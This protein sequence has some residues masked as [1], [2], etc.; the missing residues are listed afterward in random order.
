M[1]RGTS[2]N[3]SRGAPMS[4][5]GGRGEREGAHSGDGRRAGG[6]CSE[7]VQRGYEEGLGRA[8]R[9]GCKWRGQGPQG[10]CRGEHTR[11]KGG[12]GGGGGPRGGSGRL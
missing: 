5:K 9:G 8:R 3:R 11:A 1:K 12:R 2:N 4:R 6:G 7:E 10:A